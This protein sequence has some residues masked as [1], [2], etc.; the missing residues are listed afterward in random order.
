MLIII[1]IIIIIIINTESMAYRKWEQVNEPR[2]E[3][4]T[5]GY[6]V[7]YMCYCCVLCLPTVEIPTASAHLLHT[8]TARFL[9]TL[10]AY[11]YYFFDRS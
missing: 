3:P 6:Q 7:G 11:S 10:T 4:V 5:I 8:I 2:L 1:I 9:V